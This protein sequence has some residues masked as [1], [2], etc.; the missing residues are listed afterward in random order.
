MEAHIE[1]T[2]EAFGSP[3]RADT[4]LKVC[5]G[6]ENSGVSSPHTRSGVGAWIM[7]SVRHS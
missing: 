1:S 7:L 2:K 4:N 3:C 6:Y 5:G